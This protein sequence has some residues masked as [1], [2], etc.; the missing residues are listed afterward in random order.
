MGHA[1]QLLGE[2]NARVTD[3]TF[4]CGFNH[5]TNFSRQFMKTTGLTPG[6]ST[7]DSADAASNQSFF[8]FAFDP[9]AILWALRHGLSVDL[10]MEIQECATELEK[11]NEPSLLYIRVVR[12]IVRPGRDIKGAS[13]GRKSRQWKPTA[14]CY[15]DF[16]R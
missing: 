6:R 2:E 16:S 10:A 3:V 7:A 4:E 15:C 13:S 9:K 11:Q 14:Q 5:L 1:R 12:S 8:E